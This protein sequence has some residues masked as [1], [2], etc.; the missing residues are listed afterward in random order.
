MPCAMW[1]VEAYHCEAVWCFS[2][3]CQTVLKE[4]LLWA[5]SY[6]CSLNV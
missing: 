2:I 4:R 3:E 1:V 6:R 5:N